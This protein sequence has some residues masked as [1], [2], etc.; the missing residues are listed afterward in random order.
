MQTL[1]EL[2][3]FCFKGIKGENVIFLR[4]F[5]TMFNSIVPWLSEWLNMS[6]SPVYSKYLKGRWSGCSVPPPVA[7]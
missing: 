5:D 3:H 6:H 4:L 1:Q 7:E 2:G